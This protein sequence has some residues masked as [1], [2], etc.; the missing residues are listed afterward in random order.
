MIGRPKK[1]R[2][3][4]CKGFMRKGKT[5]KRYCKTAHELPVGEWLD[6]VCDKWVLRNDIGKVVL[7][8]SKERENEEV[9]K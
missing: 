2:C 3:F 9:V 5:G 7:D 1:K 4:T 8:N 6:H